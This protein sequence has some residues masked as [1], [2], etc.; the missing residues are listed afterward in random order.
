MG[1]K[2]RGTRRLLLGGQGSGSRHCGGGG[3]Q[4]QRQKRR[5]SEGLLPAPG[6][7][8]SWGPS[9]PRFSRSLPA[10][11]SFS[12]SLAPQSVLLFYQHCLVCHCFLRFLPMPLPFWLTTCCYC[13]LPMLPSSTFLGKTALLSLPLPS[14][15]CLFSVTPSAL[16]YVAHPVSFPWAVYVAPSPD[17]KL[18]TCTAS[19][20][21][22]SKFSLCVHVQLILCPCVLFLPA[23]PLLLH[24][25]N[26]VSLSSSI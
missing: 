22:L 20:P 9:L 26:F 23:C 25:K 8:V 10:S 3:W 7:V 24:F 2:R 19:T 1:E 17:V 6:A 14:D 12:G 21:L 18:L 13:I 15:L 5:G 4:R 16:H 11:I